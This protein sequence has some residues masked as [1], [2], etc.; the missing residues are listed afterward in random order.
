M[1]WNINVLF[2]NFIWNI[3]DIYSHHLYITKHLYLNSS[4]SFWIIFSAFLKLIHISFYRDID[5]YLFIK[6][7]KSV[8]FNYF[9]ITEPF[10]LP[11]ING[12]RF[13]SSL[14]SLVDVGGRYYRTIQTEYTTT[15]KAE[16]AHRLLKIIME[17]IVESNTIFI[18]S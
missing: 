2:D 16:T 13:S 8:F 7:T 14:V 10:S 18:I 12:T 5:N 17:F 3:H 6:K 1:N 15:I 4:C 11:Q 9:F